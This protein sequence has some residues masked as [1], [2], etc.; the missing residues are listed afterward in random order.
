MSI[1]LLL[2]LVGIAL[3]GLTILTAYSPS[4]Q[5]VVRKVAAWTVVI[6]VSSIA[7][8]LLFL[9]IVLN[10]ASEVLARFFAF[11]SD[12]L[13]LVTAKGGDKATAFV[14]EFPKRFS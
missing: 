3:I 9:L 6:V 13:S 7:T 11:L 1:T 14:D 5:K 8:I 2:V 12:V 10:L 4:A